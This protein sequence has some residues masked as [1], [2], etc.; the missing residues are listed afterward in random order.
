MLL[1]FLVSFFAFFQNSDLESLRNSYAKANS[2]NDATRAFIQTASKKTS[3]DPAVI[4]YKAAAQIMEAKV[5][6]EKNKRKTFVKTGATQLENVI[7]SNPNNVELRLIRLSV[8]ENLPK[9]VGYSKNIKEDKIFLIANYPKQNSAMKNY[10]K[11]FAMQSKSMS[12]AEKTI[13]K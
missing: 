2:S 6:T 5:T 12:A 1:T 9:I 11:R 10:I 8:Q 7:K 4:G 3:A 13:F